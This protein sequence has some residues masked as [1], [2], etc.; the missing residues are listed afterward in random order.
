MNKKLRDYFDSRVEAVIPQL[1]P[2]VQKIIETQTP[3]QVEDFPSEE[4][5]AE[6]GVEY[7]DELC[8]LYTGI[9]FTERSVE[10]VAPLPDQVILYRLGILL[11]VL[12]A[13]ESIPDNR[14][15][16][17][18]PN[19]DNLRLEDVN[20]TSLDEQIRI[21]ILHEL[22]HQHGLDEDDL[23]DLGYG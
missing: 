8:G 1:P 4:V 17:L 7:P 11:T 5:M 12:E 20:Q 13:D 10:D 18:E 15:Y 6:M 23:E 14:F 22:G 2:E 3:L 21:T 19:L 16:D 9:A